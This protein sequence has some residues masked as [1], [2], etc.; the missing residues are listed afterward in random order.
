MLKRLLTAAEFQPRRTLLWLL[1]RAVAMFASVPILALCDGHDKSLSN[2]ALQLLVARCMVGAALALALCIGK[3][4][5]T[6]P[7][8]LFV[9]VA[10]MAGA[11]LIWHFTPGLAE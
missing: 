11:T 9:S 5:R 8:L 1:G 2:L 3:R 7:V 4:E 10:C 6:L